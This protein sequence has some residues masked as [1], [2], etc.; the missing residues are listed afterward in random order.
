M[1]RAKVFR[2]KTMQSKN[3]IAVLLAFQFLVL[4]TI[5]LD[6]P[7]M[8]Q[9]VCFV[10][11][12]FI[13]GYLL[14]KIIRISEIG[15]TESLLISA[16]LSIAFLMFF[17]L[18]M[19][20]VYPLMGISNPLS[21]IPI[22]VSVSSV[23]SIL[24]VFTYLRSKEPAKSDG[25]E[26]VLSLITVVLISLPL[27][28]L[29]GTQLLRSYV[30][31]YLLLLMII[32]VC[33]VVLCAFSKRLLPTELFPLA[34]F[35]VSLSLLLHMSLS[36]DF[37]MGADIQI[38]YYFA[39]MV[40][41]NSV[42]DRTIAHSYNSMLS[43]TILPVIYQ[44]F[45]K[46]DIDW[47]FKIVYP[48]IYALVPVTLYIAY[49][50]LAGSLVAFLAAFFFLSI[51]TFYVQM[52]GLAREMIAELFLA[53]LILLI[54]EEKVSSPKRKLLF[55][56]I[57]AALVV[58]H[59]AL[60]YIFMVCLV[61]V[62]L[63]SLF[64]GRREPKSSRTVSLDTFSLYFVIAF[65]WNLFVSQGSISSLTSILHHIYVS[66]A[67]SA[68]APGVS[69][70]MP[71]SVS[72]IHDVHKYLF[73]LLQLFIVLGFLWLVVRRKKTQFNPEYSSMTVASMFILALCVLVPSFAQGLLIS[74]FYHIVLFF[75]AP[76]CILGPSKILNWTANLRFR[77][78]RFA[79]KRVPNHKNGVVAL[80]LVA[81]LLI[82]FFLFQVGFVY[83]VTGDVPSSI[84]LSRNHMNNW[85]LYMNDLY[86]DGGEVASARWLSTYSARE[87]TVYADTGIALLT[88]YG[89]V[90]QERITRYTED[91]KTIVGAS[92][93]I[94][95]FYFGRLNVVNG[96]VEGSDRLWKISDFS[97]IIDNMSRTY[98]NG[99]S[100]IYFEFSP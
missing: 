93:H 18:L 69:G 96:I 65:V 39:K 78:S 37:L 52:L 40:S 29:V 91:S 16:G 32:L 25:A 85:T 43:V 87:S 92:T 74:R 86:I 59:Y 62:L 47:I 75:L 76:L 8:R 42:W 81:V 50:K 30:N 21:S 28:T 71:L 26:P 46:M 4:V 98:S 64:W 48:M 1:K 83:Q 44:T 14:F 60:S 6:I 13:P 19:N 97:N 31:N 24:Y 56:F 61:F 5:F 36:T 22:T 38:E 89:S 11:L 73:Y 35:V 27:M 95:Y 3:L 34:I 41:V 99:L 20:T 58:S 23:M 54:V 80:L 77:L 57:G 72:P 49:R 88:S 53:L 45:L 94:A 15:Y 7:V 2:G 17:G 63:M 82:S 33:L 67:E 55:V 51:E 70:F 68:P 12:S 100:D 84:A 10:Y 79:K 90:P 9:V 66:L